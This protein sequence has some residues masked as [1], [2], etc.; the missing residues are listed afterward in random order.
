MYIPMMTEEVVFQV[1]QLPAALDSTVRGLPVVGAAPPFWLSES[2][3]G[4]AIEGDVN[5]FPIEVVITLDATECFI[6]SSKTFIANRLMLMDCSWV[7]VSGGIISEMP[8]N[9]MALIKA[10]A[11]CGRCGRQNR[12]CCMSPQI[13]VNG[14]TKNLADGS[15]M[16]T[17][18]CYPD[19]DNP[20]YGTVL[21]LL[22]KRARDTGIIA[23]TVGHG[24]ESISRT[25]RARDYDDLLAKEVSA[26][27]NSNVLVGAVSRGGKRSSYCGCSGGG[28]R[29]RS[30][31]GW[32]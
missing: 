6:Q 1:D 4:F 13:S 27:K 10:R 9:Y 2:G 18:Y 29:A 7:V 28:R 23:T 20:M 24:V 3:D 30:Y 19:L 31:T 17:Y 32:Y 15:Y 8:S 25:R 12:K 14:E 16:I 5:C 26:I 11:S 21:E 22:I